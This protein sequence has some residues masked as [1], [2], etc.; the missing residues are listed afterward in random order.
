MWNIEQLCK[1]FF[2]LS[3]LILVDASLDTEDKISFF[4][5][6]LLIL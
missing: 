4:I 2:C 6:W 1:I 3:L 5:Y